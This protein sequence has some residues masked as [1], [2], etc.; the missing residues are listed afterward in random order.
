MKPDAN[1]HSFS[2][3]TEACANAGPSEVAEQ[4]S[5]WFDTSGAAIPPWERFSLCQQVDWR[6][7][8]ALRDIHARPALL[9]EWCLSVLGCALP[10]AELAATHWPPPIQF[11]VDSLYADSEARV[12][13]FVL[14]YESLIHFHFICLASQFVT[15]A[16]G[17]K[18]DVTHELEVVGW[19]ILH[20]ALYDRA[21]LGG[22]VWLHRAAGL[23]KVMSAMSATVEPVFPE[24]VSLLEPSKITLHARFSGAANER[25]IFSRAGPVCA[26][27]DLLQ[28]VRNLL[29]GHTDAANSV[30]PTVSL[31]L[32]RLLGL[33]LHHFEGYRK[34][35]MGM[36]S[37]AQDAIRLACMWDDRGE[38]RHS[39]N[40]AARRR[41]MEPIWGG[42]ASGMEAPPPPALQNWDPG[43]WDESLLLFDTSA[44]R[45]RYLYLMPWGHKHPVAGA[46]RLMPGLLDSVRW[47][48]LGG[49]AHPTVVQRG[50]MDAS[51]LDSEWLDRI[52]AQL[53]RPLNAE[54]AVAALASHVQV[55][56]DLPPP[57]PVFPGEG[58]KLSFDLMHGKS[59]MAMAASSLARDHQIERVLAAARVPEPMSGPSLV[60]LIGASGAGKSV[61]MAQAY[62]RVAEH[63]M[64]FTM[65]SVPPNE[66]EPKAAIDVN[67]NSPGPDAPDA[68]DGWVSTIAPPVRMHWLAGAAQLCGENEPQVMLT[69]AE[70]AV[71]FQA[72][73]REHLKLRANKA[74]YVFIDAVNQTEHVADLFSGLLPIQALHPQVKI[75]VSTQDNHVVLQALDKLSGPVANWIR[76]DLAPWSLQEIRQL[77]Q[78]QGAKGLEVPPLSD[79]LLEALSQQTVGLPILVAHWAR[80]LQTLLAVERS[81]AC[82]VLLKEVTAADVGS[83][84]SDYLS[85]LLVEVKRDFHPRQLPQALMWCVSTISTPLDRDT[86]YEA[87]NRLRH[88]LPE[89]PSVSR[90]EIDAA[91][92][93]LAGF[94]VRDTT[95]VFP[96]W[97]LAH[98]M[99]GKV[100]YREFGKPGLTGD[101]NEALVDFG[102]VPDPSGWPAVACIHWAEMV[103]EDADQY[104]ALNVEQQTALTRGLIDRV[105]SDVGLS[106]L[107]HR[108]LGLQFAASVCDWSR[109][110]LEESGIA[111]RAIYTVAK[112]ALDSAEA[113]ADPDRCDRLFDFARITGGVGYYDWSDKNGRC[114]ESY[115]ESLATFQSARLLWPTR[116]TARRSARLMKAFDNQ[117]LVF[118]RIHDKWPQGIEFLDE[119]VAIAGSELGSGGEMRRAL[120]GCLHTRGWA[121]DHEGQTDAAL[122]DLSRAV[123]VL[124]GTQLQ[125]DSQKDQ[126]TRALTSRGSILVKVNKDLDAE[127]DLDRALALEAKRNPRNSGAHLNIAYLAMWCGN[128]A[129]S[130]MDWTKAIARFRTAVEHYAKTEKTDDDLD[131]SAI[132]ATG[133][134]DS[135]QAT[136]RLAESVD[137]RLHAIELMRSASLGTAAAG[138]LSEA[139]TTA[140]SHLRALGQIDRLRVLL[141]PHCTEPDL[142]K[143]GEFD[144]IFENSPDVRQENLGLICEEPGMNRS[145]ESV[146]AAQKTWLL[147]N[148]G[149][150]ADPVGAL[151]QRLV[152]RAAPIS[153]FANAHLVVLYDP[154]RGGR[155]EV[156]MLVKFEEDVRVLDWSNAPI[157]RANAD[158]CLDLS[159]KSQQRDYITFFFRFVRG[160]HGRFL[161]AECAEDIDWLVDADQAMVNTACEQVRP[162]CQLPAP[163]ESRTAWFA[164]MMFRD[165]LFQANIE[166]PLNGENCGQVTLGD[167]TLVLEDLPVATDPLP[168]IRPVD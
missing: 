152:V 24:T 59:A 48:T 81:S 38:V 2:R 17:P 49:R 36:T 160:R 37:V 15:M 165:S 25:D 154:E 7:F 27:F 40:D 85:R 149:F 106:M 54:M 98:P 26:A 142:Y 66:Y 10:V 58:P 22:R 42:G 111:C 140:R 99:L 145:F 46:L 134:A 133:L 12:V 90:H 65:D 83:F 51:E 44:P 34:L 124:E 14:L 18:R 52:S 79:V 158:W 3:M 166:I 5:A 39:H 101:I 28:Q 56:A 9:L 105:H 156:F 132:S 100:W 60:V 87:V 157:Y 61:V 89:M 167:E 130:C 86:L 148:C 127:N 153:F 31:G 163:D 147:D 84:P 141:G 72:W 64:F 144:L 102:A 91:L 6:K 125:S 95:A 80:R 11:R 162:M 45:L 108:L 96:R 71:R 93:R 110:E 77:M 30:K 117:A 70:A 151:R 69:A 139:M 4:F 150:R 114:A 76:V 63:A 135:L 23:S 41:F 62:E 104:D 29:H 121:R 118:C 73:T 136:E 43:W 1:L 116:W 109:G 20:I 119:A 138:M 53:Q 146:S 97:R 33:L 92:A 16:S 47:R 55:L 112:Q 13:D 115:A 8:P 103:L 129:K 107:L 82:D 50:Y 78:L 19:R 113:E 131:N 159:S 161:L 32:E 128:T 143:L 68:K 35:G 123:H 120:A 155:R 164:N 122:D 67:P 75:V 137:A 88:C 57:E 21:C 74:L 94:V 168:W 126:L